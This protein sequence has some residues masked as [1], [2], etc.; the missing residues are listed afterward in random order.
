MAWDYRNPLDQ[1][2]PQTKAKV[3]IT[4]GRD[5]D[6]MADCTMTFTQP[7]TY[8]LVWSDEFA[9]TAL[10]TTKWSAKNNVGLD[11]DEAYITSRPNNVSVSGGLLHIK[12]VREALGGR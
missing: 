1:P 11:Y 6:G 4:V 3:T 12:S 9:G 2:A 8:R 7:S 10:D 5:G